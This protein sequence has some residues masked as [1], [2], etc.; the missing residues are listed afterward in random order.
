MKKRLSR[1][2]FLEMS[3]L[4]ALGA[5]LASGCETLQER[6]VVAAAPAPPPRVGKATPNEKIVVGFI[7]LAGRA[8]GLMSAFNQYNDVELGAMCD[9]YQPHLDRAVARTD[10]K[11]KA[12]RDF[13]KLLE[14]RDLDAVVIATPPHWHPLIFIYACQAGLDVYCEK[15]MCLYPA[16]GGAMLRAARENNRVTQ[17]GTQIHADD[18]YRRVVEIVRSG[19]LGDIS[20][21]RNTLYHNEAPEVL[22]N[23]ADTDPPEGLD[24][25]MWLGPSQWR[26]FNQ[27]LFEAG[28]HRYFKQ[29]I[30]SWLNEMGAHM[31]DLPFWALELGPPEAISAVA[32]R[33]TMTDISTIPDTMEVIYEYPNFMMTW[34][35]QCAS[36]FG[37]FMKGTS[38]RLLISFH[39]TDGTLLAEYGSYELLDDRGRLESKALPTPYIPSSNGHQREFLDC[40]KTRERCS[41]DVEY[42]YP[43]HLA[44]NLPH[45]ASEVGRRIRW[46]A[47]KET[48]VGD[49]EARRLSTPEYRKPWVLPA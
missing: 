42:H 23:V 11:A 34:S 22:G 48:I 8:T 7:G 49:A 38:R 43:I 30:G 39:G 47:E 40:V 45:I 14:Q 41:C 19:I 1:R 17:I 18:N 46:D 12:Y 3:S 44:M 6:P 21:V 20:V 28:H 35:N 32:G 4:T 10:G 24:W 13:R 26:P 31:L 27:A 33:Y 29:F 16:E 9:V 2:E 37:R 25:D 15:P 36:S 5:G